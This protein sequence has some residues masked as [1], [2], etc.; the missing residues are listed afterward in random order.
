MSR[1]NAFGNRCSTVSVWLGVLSLVFL[2][3]FFVPAVSFGAP[4]PANSVPR[5]FLL[6]CVIAE[7]CL[8]LAGFA[9]GCT[10]LLIGGRR[11]MAALGVLMNGLGLAAWFL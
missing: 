5:F 9:T 11:I 1:W 8:A 3:L 2:A 4:P 7:L 6:S 10:G